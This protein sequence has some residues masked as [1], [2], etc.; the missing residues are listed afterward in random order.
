MHTSNIRF[1]SPV[2]FTTE[3]DSPDLLPCGKSGR[4]PL[5]C[6]HKHSTCYRVLGEHA[7]VLVTPNRGVDTFQAHPSNLQLTSPQELGKLHSRSSQCGT[8]VSWA[9]CQPATHSW[10]V[11]ELRVHTAPHSVGP[12]FFLGSAPTATRS[13]SLLESAAPGR[14]SRCGTRGFLGLPQ[15]RSAR[16]VPPGVCGSWPLLALW[17]LGSPPTRNTLLFLQRRCILSN[18]NLRQ[19]QVCVVGDHMA[20][21]LEVVDGYRRASARCDSTLDFSP[22]KSP[23]WEPQQ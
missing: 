2:K 6:P 8:A 22:P 1:R 7:D 14:S 19:Q 5:R 15:T 4:S 16:L 12:A 3:S 13:W 23:R 9:H 20:L 18:S 10:S 17:D 11:L 21:R